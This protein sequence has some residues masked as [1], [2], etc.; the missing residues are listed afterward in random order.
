MTHYSRCDMRKLDPEAVIFLSA[1]F[2]HIIFIAGAA[3]LYW[4]VKALVR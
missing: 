4:I 1:M 2:A 3:M